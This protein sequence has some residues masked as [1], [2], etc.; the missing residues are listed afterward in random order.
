RP[1][2]PAARCRP[3]S[4]RSARRDP[5]SARRDR[6]RPRWRPPG[7]RRRRRGSPPAPASASAGDRRGASAGGWGLAPGRDAGHVL[8]APTRL[9][10]FGRGLGG[11]ERLAF[12][13]LVGETGRRLAAVDL[14]AGRGWA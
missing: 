2:R 1:R 7:R 13:R 4:A 12:G 3:G 6:R 8:L 9:G 11:P 14:L 5:R 10:V